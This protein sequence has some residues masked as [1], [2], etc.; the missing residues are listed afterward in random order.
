MSFDQLL[1]KHAL[2]LKIFIFCSVA[3]CIVWSVRPTID[4]MGK[5]LRLSQKSSSAS[6][7][8]HEPQV[9]EAFHSFDDVDINKLTFDL[10]SKYSTPYH[11]RIERTEVPVAHP[12]Q[13]GQ[14]LTQRVTLLGEFV[15]LLKCLNEVSAKLPSIKIT[16]IQFRREERDKVPVLIATVY[17]Q[18]VKPLEYEKK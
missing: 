17:F 18:S 11:V 12:E 13:G 15:P 2:A 3:L 10:I 9:G 1:L 6:L 14:I 4:V 8:R 5:S 16:S 7:S